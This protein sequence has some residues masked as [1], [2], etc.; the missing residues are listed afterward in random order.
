MRAEH[1]HVEATVT[2]G[3]EKEAKSKASESHGINT[4]PWIWETK[5]R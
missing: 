2:S 5:D 4:T 1:C 3:V